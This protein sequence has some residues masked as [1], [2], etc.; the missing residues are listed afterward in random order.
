MKAPTS[1]FLMTALF[2]GATSAFAQGDGKHEGALGQLEQLSC[3]M[4]D[5]TELQ[6]E[7]AELRKK[8]GQEIEKAAAADGLKLSAE[9]MDSILL[10][11]HNLN[12]T[13]ACRFGFARVTVD[14]KAKDDGKSGLTKAQFEKELANPKRG[15][16]LRLERNAKEVEKT[17]PGLKLISLPE[18]KNSFVDC[19][20][21]NFNEAGKKD[22]EV[23]RA[24]FE[25]FIRAGGKIS[26]IEIACSASTLRNT[27]GEDKSVETI[28]HID[29]SL[30]RCQALQ[31]RLTEDANRVIADMNAKGAKIEPLADK[32]F[33]LDPGG[34]NQDGTSGPLPPDGYRCAP[35][36]QGNGEEPHENAAQY[37][38]YKY[39]KVTI[40]GVAPPTTEKSTVETVSYFKPYFRNCEPVAKKK[41]KKTKVYRGQCPTAEKIK[42]KKNPKVEKVFGSAKKKVV[43]EAG[44]GG[45]AKP[46]K[47]STGADQSKQ[48]Q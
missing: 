7:L 47:T 28:S 34:E 19:D 9:E 24:E 29:L 46:A 38:A 23:L 2:L 25:K 44:T 8:Y 35:D 36:I 1:L 39:S 21:E 48:A 12:Y 37:D 40:L 18:M 45:T 22:Y 31:R 5:D 30:K 17:V 11:I 6:N 20:T 43:P 4:C 3:S 14:L 41:P 33:A 27:C 10:R 13:K 26:Q 15:P 42:R 32:T 16:F